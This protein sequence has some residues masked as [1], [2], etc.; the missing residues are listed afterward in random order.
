MTA[1]E[2]V[3]TPVATT[4]VREVF[5]KE[6][7]T[8]ARAIADY[9][10][11]TSPRTPETTNTANAERLVAHEKYGA[12][13]RYFVSFSGDQAQATAILLN[14][15]ENV[16]GKILPMA[17]IG[18]VASMPAGRRQGHVRQIFMGM[19]EEMRA[20]GQIVSTL[21]PFRESFY[22]R[23]GYVTAPRTRF[24]TFDPANLAPLVR[25][26]LPG[27]VEQVSMV[28]G[29][30]TWRGFIE[31]VQRTTH[32]FALRPRSADIRNRDEN[33][34]WIA[35]A[36]DDE[37]VSTGAMTFV[38]TGY[39]KSLDV[40]RFYATTT[41]AKYQLLSW[42]GRHVDQVK[43]ARI[44]IAADEYADLW[45]RDLRSQTSTML[46][47]PWPGPTMRVIS[48]DGLT[49]IEAGA[50]EISI[51]IS[52]EYAPWNN[53]VFTFAGRDGALT[54]IPGGEPALELTIQGL[55]ALVFCG[56]DPA[57]FRYRGWGTPDAAAQATL[58]TLFPKAFPILHEG[59]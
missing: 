39:G 57:D 19:Y 7:I 46:D 18:A 24:V 38:I 48:V 12:D 59:F 1:T 37:G 14:M 8:H 47:E 13:S 16:R 23:L 33:S 5:G 4:T 10:F 52:D 28:D 30:E 40:D 29:W 45:F 44:G 58:R 27:C 32:G 2:I 36:Y 26:D 35:F 31:E 15:T 43:Q 55:S 11:G 6:I 22:E 41:D 3:S 51:R 53:G 25:M 20:S 56:H 9:A 17:G 34:R 49:G 54:V 21:Y 42:I 50:G